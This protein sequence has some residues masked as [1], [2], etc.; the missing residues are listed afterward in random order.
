MWAVER[1]EGSPDI[2]FQI[3]LTTG[4]FVP[5]VDY[6]QIVGDGILNDID[7]I[8]VDPISGEIYGVSND[9]GSRDVLIR[10]NKTT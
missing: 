5:D 2:L 1:N 6:L 3:N 9:N 10:V 4:Q 8:A 7:D